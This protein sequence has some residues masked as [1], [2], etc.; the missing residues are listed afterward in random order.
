MRFGAR[1]VSLA[2]LVLL[3]GAPAI[4]SAGPKECIAFA[5]D[6][7]K[8][9]DDG[10]LH[11][12]RDK[13]IACAAKTCPAVVSKQCNQWLGEVE[14]EIPSLTFKATD[15]DGKDITDAK[16][17]VDGKELASSVQSRALPIDPGEHT[18]RI[19]RSDGKSLEEK[20]VVRPGEKDRLVALAFQPPPKPA[21]PATNNQPPP[22][23]PEERP[24]HIPTLA[25]VGAG[26][27]VAG[28]ITT[29]VFAMSAKGDEDDLRSRCAPNCPSSEKSSID[30]KLLLANVGMVVGLAGLGFAVVVTILD[31][32]KAPPPAAASVSL[33]VGPTGAGVHG[34][35]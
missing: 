2:S 26:V 12:A 8:L 32:K 13:F 7:Q 19:E 5:D 21:T 29:I 14:K 22:A 27:G 20:V 34:S 4:A 1:A 11:A 35:F 30:T 24:F 17:F 9:R 18:V 10:K 15:E 6:G 33:D 31:N 3:V 23:A 25:L 28:A 16:I